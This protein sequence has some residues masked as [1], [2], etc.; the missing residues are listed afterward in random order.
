MKSE[1]KFSVAGLY[2]AV[3][4]VLVGMTIGF[5]LLSLVYDGPAVVR[6]IVYVAYLFIV[7]FMIRSVV[8]L[9]RAIRE[10]EKK[11]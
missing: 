3:G 5:V 10:E 8:R 1:K 2:V 6:L 11:R 4:M 9:G 7:Y